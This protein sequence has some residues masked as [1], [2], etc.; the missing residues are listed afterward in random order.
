MGKGERMGE[1]E[2]RRGEVERESGLEESRR[3]WSPEKKTDHVT[4]Q[5]TCQQ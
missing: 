4:C 3:D 2:T 5:L 1:G